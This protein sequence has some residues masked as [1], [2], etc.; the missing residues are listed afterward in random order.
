M[1]AKDTQIA[2]DHYKKLAIQ[3]IEYNMANGLNYCQG[4]VVKYVTRYPDKNGVEDLLKAR[5]YIDLLIEHIEGPE[6]MG[7][8]VNADRE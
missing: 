3:P 2:G 7:K 1:S 6:G 4:N 8:V 5:H